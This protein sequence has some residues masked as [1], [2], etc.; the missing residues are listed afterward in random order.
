MKTETLCV[1]VPRN[2]FLVKR[3][4]MNAN[5]FH[6]S[7]ANCAFVRF[8]YNALLAHDSVEESAF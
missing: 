7:R 8:L 3:A 4:Q 5:L 1:G 2:A 6:S